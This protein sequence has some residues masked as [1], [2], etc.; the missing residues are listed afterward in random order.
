MIKITNDKETKIVTRGAYNSF[1]KPLGFKIIGE[2]TIKK[3]IKEEPK[4]VQ[5]QPKKV[6]KDEEDIS[7]KENIKES[8]KNNKQE[9]HK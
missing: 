2:S 3:E 4:K 6:E 1:Y 7:I 5:E 8:S 9:K